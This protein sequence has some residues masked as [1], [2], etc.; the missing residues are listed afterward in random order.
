MSVTRPGSERSFRRH[1]AAA[2]P[3]RRRSDSGVGACVPAAPLLA[4]RA[5]LVKTVQVVQNRRD[6]YNI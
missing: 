4:A 6:A 2:D 1:R 3:A 5:S